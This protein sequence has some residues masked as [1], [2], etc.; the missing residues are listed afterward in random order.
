MS[1]P[2]DPGGDGAPKKIAPKLL[3]ESE[4]LPLR[5]ES[6]R[7]WCAKLSLQIAARAGLEPR[8]CHEVSLVVAELVANAVRHGGG[9]AI[10]FRCLDVGLEVELIDRGPGF[11][12]EQAFVDGYSRGRRRVPGETVPGETLGIGLGA[13]RRLMS[14]L[15]VS[16]SGGGT[17][18]RARRYRKLPPR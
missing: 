6:D 15:E 18:V 1:S 8:A 5:D 3:S 17:R 13:A 9:G 11:D 7:F 4:P 2:S 16:V 14:E 12:L 10:V